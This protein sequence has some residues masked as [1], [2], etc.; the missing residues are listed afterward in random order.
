M[1]HFFYKSEELDYLA[2][3]PLSHI[4]PN[5]E[6]RWDHE[7]QN[8]YEK[9]NSFSKELNKL[10]F[11]LEETLPRSNYH[12]N[13]D[14]LAEYVKVNLKWKIEKKGNRWV[15]NDYMSIIEQGGFYDFDEANLI[16]AASGRIFAA[17]KFGQQH[18]D[19]MEKSHKIMLANVLSVIL[20]HRTSR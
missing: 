17:I 3:R 18:F 2:L 6:L 13:E 7:T 15:G 11:E 4:K 1:K 9:S 19:E 20:Y 5:W 14:I 10:I 8:Y 12:Y 16:L